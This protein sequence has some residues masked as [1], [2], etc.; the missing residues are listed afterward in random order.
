M[1][2]I[3]VIDGPVT[4]ASFNLTDGITSVGRSSDNDICIS[5]IGVSRHHAK[6][7]KKNGK[8]FIVDLGSRHG[9]FVDGNKIAQGRE[10]E[11]EKDTTIR[12]GNTVLSFHKRSAGEKVAQ[13]YLTFRTVKYTDKTSELSTAMQSSRDYT[14]SLELLLWVSNI[15]SQSLNI[16]DLLGE[17]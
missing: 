9:V 15:F 12:V 17:V 10:V 1:E 7:L 2:K 4:G 5:D 8:I 11:I 13:R 6:F 16:D 3:H 14:R